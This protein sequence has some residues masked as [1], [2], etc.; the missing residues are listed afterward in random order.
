MY[1]AHNKPPAELAVIKLLST[2]AGELTYNS[3]PLYC[4]ENNVR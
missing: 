4:F 3:L 1:F 2:T